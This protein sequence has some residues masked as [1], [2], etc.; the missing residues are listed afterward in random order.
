MRLVITEPAKRHLREIHDYYKQFVSKKIADKIKHG[1][2]EKLKSIQNNPQIGQ[3]EEFLEHL[4]LNHRRMVEGNY[5]IIYRVDDETIFVTDI[6][7]ARQ[8]PDKISG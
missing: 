3:K 4:K 1:I 5:K 8:N 7:D 2:I 6:F